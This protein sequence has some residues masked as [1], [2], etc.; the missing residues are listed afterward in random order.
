MAGPR[1]DRPGATTGGAGGGILTRARLGLAALALVLV[2]LAA[3]GGYLLGA[4][5]GED[6]EAARRAGESEGWQQGTAIGGNVYPAGLEVGRRITYGRAFRSAYRTAY[7]GAFAGSGV[8]EPPAEKVE[9]P[10]P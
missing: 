9:V 4:A 1:N 3:A 8:D 7:L 10:T 2:A 6:V 5:S